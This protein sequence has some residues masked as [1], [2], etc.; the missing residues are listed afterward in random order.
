MCA[1]GGVGLVLSGCK[2]HHVFKF[3]KFSGILLCISIN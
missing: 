1:G 3:P 2:C